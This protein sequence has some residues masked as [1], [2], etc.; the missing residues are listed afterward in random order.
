MAPHAV[1]GEA[2]PWLRLGSLTRWLWVAL[3]MVVVLALALRAARL[4]ELPGSYPEDLDGL[5]YGGARLL[6]GELLHADFVTGQGAITQFLYALS[7]QAGSLRLHRLLIVGVDGVGGLLLARSLGYLAQ[8]GWI[9]WRRHSPLPVVAGGLYVVINQCVPDGAA[10]LPPHFANLFLAL[11]LATACYLGVRPPGSRACLPG[12][13]GLGGWLG[14]AMAT[15]PAL[16]LPLLTLL[17][18]AP[19]V[20]GLRPPLV[21]LLAGLLVGLVLPSVPCLLRPGGVALAWSGEVLLPLLAVDPGT[22]PVRATGP[23]L[24]QALST[25]VAGLPLGSLLVLPLGAWL[26]SRWPARQ[27]PA[28]A[29]PGRMAA[30]A[31]LLLVFGL[32]LM[33]TLRRDGLQRA[34]LAFLAFPLVLLT[35]LGLGALETDA[36]PW[37]RRMA[38]VCSLILSLLLFNNLAVASLL[39]PPR[40]PAESVRALEQDRARL[41][42]YLASLPPRERGFTAPQDVALQRRLNVPAT[43]RGIGPRWSLDQQH[44]GQHWASRVLGLPADANGACG[45]LTAARNRHLVWSRIDPSVAN[46]LD[47]FRSCLAREGDKWEDITAR[48]GLVGGEMKLFRRLPP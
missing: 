8:A 2:R 24:L 29:R 14:L 46:S 12:L 30:L 33:E 10:G 7:A 18:L 32:L 45:Q 22:A 42:A 43:T 44:L 19:F 16:A 38:L 47:F 48:L 20:L 36:R 17:A 40:K 25:P 41:A 26:A 13:L 11:A 9:R 6:R 15:R 37:P 4:P 3:W 27:R 1:P 5:L 21:P 35:V 23:I 34:E 28:A 39:H 31:A